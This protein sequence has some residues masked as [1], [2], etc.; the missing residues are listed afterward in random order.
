M[1]AKAFSAAWIQRTLRSCPWTALLSPPLIEFLRDR[2]PMSELT[3]VR[4]SE[5]AV[6]SIDFLGQ[7]YQSGAGLTLGWVEAMKDFAS[8][9]GRRRKKS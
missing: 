4:L 2:L 9:S 1:A 7:L 3:R 8:L 6:T 5:K